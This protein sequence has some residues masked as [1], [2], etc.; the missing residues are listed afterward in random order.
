[1]NYILLFISCLCNGMKSVF[2]KIS[3]KHLNEKHNIYTYNF[4]TFAISFLVAL[5]MGITSLKSASIQTAIMAAMYGAFLVFGQIF[6]I[7][8]MKVGEVSVS[9]LFYSC[10]FLIPSFV[11]VFAY[12]EGLSKLQTIGILMILA[13]FVISV[14][15]RGKG[16]ST[17]KW[18][19]FAVL[20]FLCNGFTGL[21]QKIFRMSEFG[22]EQNVFVMLAFLTGAVITFFVM[23][24]NFKPL[25]SK[26][27]LGTV[28]GSGL[29]LGFVNVINVYI[30]GVLP[31]I[32]VF[33]SI[34]GGGIIFSAILARI[35]IKEK[36]SLRKKIGIAVG[37]VAICLIAI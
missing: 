13:S 17:L 26:G 35:L 12:D 25:P 2:A 18:F 24:K 21:M 27:F 36:I 37:V 28:L 8:A 11:S 5:P 3:N 30:S 6:L 4:Y 16:A 15:K 19:V 34:N 29:M 10:G 20:S 33:P 32:I 22:T 31:G 23:P 7:K 1:M 9:M 14:E